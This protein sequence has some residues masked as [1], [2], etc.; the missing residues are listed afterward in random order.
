MRSKGWGGGLV[1]PGPSPGP[2]GGRWGKPG[3]ALRREGAGTPPAG[4]LEP[5]VL[6]ELPLP[7][8]PEDQVDFVGITTANQVQVH[9]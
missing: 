5:T 7:R 6:Q 2:G 4:A 8:Q 9:L 1:T 3:T